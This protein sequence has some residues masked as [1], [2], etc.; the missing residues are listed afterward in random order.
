VNE[1]LTGIKLGE[2]PQLRLGVCP[3]EP[4]ALTVVALDKAY[5]NRLRYAVLDH[6]AVIVALEADATARYPYDQQLTPVPHSPKPPPLAPDTSDGV[7]APIATIPVKPAP[8]TAIPVAIATSTSPDV[9]PVRVTAT[10]VGPESITLARP[11]VTK[12]ADAE[13]PVFE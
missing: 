6:E 10:E 1:P 8:T 9:R 12:V 5:T 11:D 3:A 4:V 2:T 13:P 7:L